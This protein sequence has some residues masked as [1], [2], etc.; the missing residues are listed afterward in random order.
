M[1]KRRS[2]PKVSFIMPVL[3]EEKTISKCLD[4]LLNLDY[5]MDKI[6]V[7]VARGPS[8]DNTNKI[9]DEYAKEHGN[10]KLLDNPTGNTAIGRNI[11]I[12][13]ATGEMLMNYSGHVIAERNLLR[14]LALKLSGLPEEVAGVGCSNLSPEEQNFVGKASGVAFLGFMG[15]GNLFHQNAVFDDERYVEHMSFTCYRKEVVEKVGNFDPDLWCGQDAE[16]DI[17]IKKAGYKIL[18]TPET[19]VY[20]FK[21][22][23]V[24]SLFRQMY[25]YGVARA[26][27]IKKH[28]DT[29][30]V[31]YL[32]GAGF[33]TGLI[34]L[35]ILLFLGFVPL[36]FVLLL[37]LLYLL[38]AFISSFQVTRK[39]SLVLSS[40]FFYFLI[41]LAYGTG[42]I[43]GVVYSRL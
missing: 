41:H 14:V 8:T 17:R 2:Y 4:S 34:L 31:P 22:P 35:L 7:L 23:T 40:V 9:L 36:W 5:P 42:F 28:P 10:M 6:E 43:R 29:F 33:V 26:I 32:F 16:L 12:E 37:A 15:G 13:H 3:N 21:R 25:R 39:V 27:I 38:L 18:Y 20:H 30:R 19:R 24:R 1:K 11:C